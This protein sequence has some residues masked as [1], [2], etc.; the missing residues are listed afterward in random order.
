MNLKEVF[1]PSISWFSSQAAL[2]HKSSTN[3]VISEIDSSENMNLFEYL[4]K[5]YK[6]E[7]SLV[8]NYNDDQIE[9]EILKQKW[10]AVRVSSSSCFY[11]SAIDCGL[12]QRNWISNKLRLLKENLFQTRY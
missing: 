3:E 10:I 5:Q 1:G 11:S 8:L 2:L 9:K 7:L 12:I 4:L 6:D